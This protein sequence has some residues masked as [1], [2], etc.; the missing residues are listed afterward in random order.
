M[1]A[2]Q[3]LSEY[4]NNLAGLNP[5]LFIGSLVWIGITGQ[6]TGE[7]YTPV[8]VTLPWLVQQ[9]QAL[10]LDPRFLP[11][12][13]N[14]IN[15]FKKVTTNVTRKYPGREEGSF[16]TLLVREVALTPEY[17]LRKI[18]KEVRSTH[19]ETLEYSTN[20]ASL[21]YY[22]GQRSGQG[23]IAGTETLKWAV[24]NTVDEDDE[25]WVQSM[26]EEILEAYREG[27]ER[28]HSDTI[29]ELFRNIVRSL[30]AI[31]VK[32]QA[33]IYFV[34]NGHQVTLDALKQLALRIGQGCEFHQMPLLDTVDQRTM[35]TEKFQDD[36]EVS[37]AS[38]VAKMDERAAQGVL[39]SKAYAVL[40]SQLNTIMERATEYTKLLNVA[41]GRS[42]AALEV[43]YDSL[44]G[45]VELIKVKK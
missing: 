10:D 31:A 29:R 28:V 34:Q 7:N 5:E 17:V 38:L 35:L 16:V 33:G 4:Q 18:V 30:Q 40:S 3:S 20:L 23:L 39:S 8:A 12:P 21:K 6:M 15:I 36:I 9:F 2:T 14:P 37:V 22:R 24:L 1:I 13:L 25:P 45:L 32:P 44:Q 19:T 43:A 27:C 42:G 41:Q 26:L 11:C